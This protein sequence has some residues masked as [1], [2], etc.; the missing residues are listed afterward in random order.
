MTQEVEAKKIV[1]YWKIGEVTVIEIHLDA[2]PN[3]WHRFWAKNLLGIR[4]V[5]KDLEPEPKAQGANESKGIQS[6]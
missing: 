4:W 2:K 5:D 6:E 3:A 1:G